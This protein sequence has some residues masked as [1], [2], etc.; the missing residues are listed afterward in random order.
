MKKEQR[1]AAFI[2]QDELALISKM[3]LLVMGQSLGLDQAR[4]SSDHDQAWHSEKGPGS[5]SLEELRNLEL[6]KLYVVEI[7]VAHI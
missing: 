7:R 1:A 4:F 3:L 6:I 2:S 5:T